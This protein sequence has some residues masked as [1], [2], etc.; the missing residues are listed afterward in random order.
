MAIAPLSL[1]LQPKIPIQKMHNTHLHFAE[2]KNEPVLSYAP[3]SAER[4]ALQAALADAKKA[5]KDIPMYINGEEVR[6]GDKKVKARICV[7][8][9]TTEFISD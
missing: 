4:K 2:P 5:V 1:P 8:G 3:G 6:S 9:C 7:V